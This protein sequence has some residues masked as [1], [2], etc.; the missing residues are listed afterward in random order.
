MKFNSNQTEKLVLSCIMDY[1]DAWY[2]IAD[3]ISE[4]LFT[5][6][7]HQKVYRSCAKLANSNRIPDMLSVSE[8]LKN[9]KDA[10][11]R[12]AEICQKSLSLSALPQYVFRLKEYYLTR[13][14][15]EL[16]TEVKKQLESGSDAIDIMTMAEDTIFKMNSME[17]EQKSENISPLIEKAIFDLSELVSGNKGNLYYTGFTEFDN[18]L[19]GFEAGNLIYLAARP[20]QGKSTLTLNILLDMVKRGIPCHL[21]SLEMTKAEVTKNIL[22]NICQINRQDIK[23]G[24]LTQDEFTKMAQAHQDTKDYPLLIDDVYSL[25]FQALRA[26]LKRSI[27]QQG[28]KICVIDYIQLMS[29]GKPDGRTREQQVSELSRNLKLLAKECNIPIIGV[30]QLSRSV[31]NRGSN[32]VYLSDLRESGSLEQ[33]AN[34]VIFIHAPDDPEQ[35]ER[36]LKVVKIAKN[37]AGSTSSILMEFEGQYLTFRNTNEE[38]ATNQN[39]N[40]FVF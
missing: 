15:F 19:G 9:E 4:E 12:I 32:E 2:T 10:M 27:H 35:A 29:L 14:L 40:R 39:N 1:K 3:I 22:S 20:A 16:T 17:G 28:T 26:K 11:S 8:D 34:V 5:D 31:E 13:K 36:G 30:S 23:E 33:D 18:V 24:R 37:R 38:I 21:F 7:F 6:E 25:N